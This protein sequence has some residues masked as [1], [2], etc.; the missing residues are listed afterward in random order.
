MWFEVCVPHSPRRSVSGFS[1][2]AHLLSILLA[3]L[4]GVSLSLSLFRS[5]IHT[6]THIHKH[7]TYIYIYIYMSTVSGLSSLAT[8]KSS[9][10]R[11]AAFACVAPKE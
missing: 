2:T 6:H 8:A 10:S 9:S 3:C 5:H 4:L 1:A 7:Y 11:R